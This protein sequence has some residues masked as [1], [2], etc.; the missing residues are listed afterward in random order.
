MIAFNFT[1]VDGKGAQLN[2]ITGTGIYGSTD[3]YAADQIRIWNPSTSGYEVWFYWFDESDHSWDGWWDFPNAQV[4]FKDVHPDGLVNGTAAWYLSANESSG[5]TASFAG[6]VDTA[7]SVTMTLTKGNFNMIGNPFPVG[8]Q[9]NN[10][11]QVTWE[12]AFGSTDGYAADQIRIWNPSTSGYEVWFYWFDESDHSWDG[13]WDFPN[14]QV[15][16]QDTHPN[17]LPAGVPC[18]YLSAAPLGGTFD[19]TFK[20]PLK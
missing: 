14:A 1:S 19:V 20:T 11:D 10:Q 6:A 15:E 12:N 4:E 3:G 7:K 18:W 16:F 2:D 13:W 17:G 5:G 8:F 9:L